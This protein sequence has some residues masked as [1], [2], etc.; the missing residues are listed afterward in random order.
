MYIL[1]AISIL[2]FFALVLAAI[3]I[4]RHVR[5]RRISAGQQTD[6][7]H[8]LFAAAKDQDAR[9]PRTLTQQ[10]IRDVVARASWNR[11]LEPTLADTRNQSISSKRL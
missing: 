6:F 5:T 11:A 2:C 4:A 1:L 3:A 10:N 9:T 7:A 8:H